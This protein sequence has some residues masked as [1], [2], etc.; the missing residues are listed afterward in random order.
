MLLNCSETTFHIFVCPEKD[1][2]KLLTIDL[3]RPMNVG[4]QEGEKFFLYFD[5]ILEIKDVTGKIYGFSK[6]KVRFKYLFK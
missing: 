6:C 1:S 5:S 2:K 4:N 3:K